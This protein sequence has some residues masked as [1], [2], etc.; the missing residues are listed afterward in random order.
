MAGSLKIRQ[1]LFFEPLA[2]FAKQQKA[3]HVQVESPFLAK[4]VIYEYRCVV[5]K[6]PPHHFLDIMTLH[7]IPGALHLFAQSAS[8]R[9]MLAVQ[10]DERHVATIWDRELRMHE[11]AKSMRKGLTIATLY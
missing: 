8:W 4:L 10:S 5:E 9:K 6:S 1:A 2:A 7:I 3:E 11:H